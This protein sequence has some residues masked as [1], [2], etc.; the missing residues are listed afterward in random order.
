MGDAACVH[1]HDAAHSMGWGYP[2]QHF[3]DSAVWPPV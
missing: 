1:E 3:E 2:N